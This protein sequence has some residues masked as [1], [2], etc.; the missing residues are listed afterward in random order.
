MIY[1]M[2][3]FLTNDLRVG[4]SDLSIYRLI[5]ESVRAA[6]WIGLYLL[7]STRNLDFMVTETIV[8]QHMQKESISDINLYLFWH[9]WEGSSWGPDDQTFNSLLFTCF[10]G[11]KKNRL[12]YVKVIF[13]VS[14][15]IAF[16]LNNRTRNSI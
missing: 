12:Y 7:M 4:H 5:Q 13:L 10:I 6:N 1:V 8:K 14:L 15:L 11:Y 9:P 16:T 3:A 2:C